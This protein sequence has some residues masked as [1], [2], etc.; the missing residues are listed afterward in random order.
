M[1]N[2]FTVLSRARCRSWGS[3]GSRSS[4]TNRKTLESW[5][6][7]VDGKIFAALSSVH[8]GEYSCYSWRVS[9]K[10]LMIS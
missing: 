7:P 10:R 2:R 5:A 1:G 6:E 4:Q 8:Q 9:K 3:T